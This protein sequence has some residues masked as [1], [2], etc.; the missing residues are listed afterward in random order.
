MIPIELTLGAVAIC[1]MLY[2]LASVGDASAVHGAKNRAI[3]C[4][5]VQVLASAAFALS[6]LGRSRYMTMWTLL[7]LILGMVGLLLY[8]RLLRQ[9]GERLTAPPD[10]LQRLSMPF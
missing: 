4:G 10:E 8:V 2:A 7:G 9:V 5:V 1:A 3:S 6:I